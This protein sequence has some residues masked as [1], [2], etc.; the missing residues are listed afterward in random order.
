MKT[1]YVAKTNTA[2]SYDVKAAVLVFL[3][4]KTAAM[5]VYLTISLKVRIFSYVTTFCY[6]NKYT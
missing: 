4:T 2:Y 6:S 1:I 3:N 5:L